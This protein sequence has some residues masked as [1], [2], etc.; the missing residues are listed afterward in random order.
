MV[1]ELKATFK[2]TLGNTTMQIFCLIII[3]AWRF[4]ARH[5]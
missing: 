3:G 2:S 4:A 5:G 1:G